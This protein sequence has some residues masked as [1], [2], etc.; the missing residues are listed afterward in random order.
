MALATSSART[1]RSSA[2]TW[3]SHDLDRSRF[4]EDRDAEPGQGDGV[5]LIPVYT[6]GHASDHLCYFLVEEQA[7]FTGDVSLAGSTTV[8]PPADGDLTAYMT[9]LRRLQ[10]LDVRR[11]YP[12]HGPVV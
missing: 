7:R 10:Q 5:T 12:A 1:K 4:P 6:P 9:S 11:I 3:A 2:A 8:I